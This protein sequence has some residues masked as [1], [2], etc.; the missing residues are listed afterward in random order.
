M[1]EFDYRELLEECSMLD[2]YYEQLENE[3]EME[4]LMNWTMLYR[5]NM[6]ITYINYEG[7]VRTIGAPYIDKMFKIKQED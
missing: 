7:E 1:R 6:Q 5:D 3:L 4:K 2:E